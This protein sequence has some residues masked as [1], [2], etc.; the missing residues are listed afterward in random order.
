MFLQVLSGSV[1]IVSTAPGSK[2]FQLIGIIHQSFKAKSLPDGMV[3][4]F[5]MSFCAENLR[6][7]IYTPRDSTN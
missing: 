4:H 1:H 2:L 7:V 5:R 3:C 6:R